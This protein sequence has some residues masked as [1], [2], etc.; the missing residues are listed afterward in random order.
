MSRTLA[1]VGIV[2]AL[3]PAALLALLAAQVGWLYVLR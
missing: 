1:R 3:A 2:L